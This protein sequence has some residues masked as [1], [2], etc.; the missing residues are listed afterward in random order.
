MEYDIEEI[1]YNFEDDYNPGPRP[2][3]QGPRN[4]YAGGQLVQPSADGLRPGYAEELPDNVQKNKQGNYVYR[5][6]SGDDRVYKSGFKTP[7]AASKWGQKEFVKKFSL[8]NKFV[9]AGELGKILG[10]SKT[11][12]GTISPFFERSDRPNYLLQEARKILGSYKTGKSNFFRAPTKKEIEYL[13]K[14]NTSPIIPN[15][16]AKNVQL[17]LNNKAIMNDLTGKN[18]GGKTLPDFKKIQKVFA[19]HNKGHPTPDRDSFHT[20]YPPRTSHN[21]F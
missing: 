9:N 8:P 18:K 15:Q 5:S 10:I 3:N 12:S 20:V 17:I 13:K 4:M 1:L 2:M 7:E 11:G 6:G 16:V 19:T 14:Y 21:V